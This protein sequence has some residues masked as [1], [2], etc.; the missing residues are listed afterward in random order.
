[1][2]L[3]AAIPTLFLSSLVAVSGQS[4][5]SPAR[6]PALPLAVKSPY[7]STWLAAGSLGGNGG[8]LPGEWPTFWNNIVTGWTGLIRVDNNTY[9]WMGAPLPGVADV[10]LANQ[11]SYTYTSTKSIFSL[12]AGPVTLNVT[13]L[14]PI[15][16]NDI[17]RQ[18]IISSYVDVAVE[19]NDGNSH[20]VQLYTDI[21]AEWVSG[22]RG[23]TVQWNYDTTANG[24][25]YHQVFRQSQLAFTEDAD[26]TEYGN[27]YWA[28][29][30]SDALSYQS[31]ADNDVRGQFQNNGVLTN[32]QDTNFRA[33]NDNYP[34]FGFASALGSVTGSISTLYTIGLY[35]QDAVQFLGQNGVESVPTLWTSYFGSDTD[36][37][38]FFYGDYSTATST[39]NDLDNQ[40]ASDA[41]A[42]GGQDL[43]TI[44]SL[45]VR[46]AFGGTEFGG[47]DDQ[48]LLWM[49]EISSNGNCQTV[50][51][52][53]PLHPIHL[54]FN[55]TYIKYL[56][57]PLFINQ[58]SGNYPNQYSMHDLGAHFPNDTGHTDGQDEFMPVE[59]S[60][61]MLIMT[62]AYAQKTGDNDYLN[63]HYDI[64]KQWTGFL[65]NDSLIPENQVSTDDFA[66]ALAN[67]TNLA[68]KGIIGIAAMAEIANI[69]GNTDDASN[70]RSTAEDYINQWYDLGNA[71][72]AD[73]PHTTLDYGQNDSWN[74]LYNLY[75]DAL[76]GLGL[77]KQEIYT[78]QANWYAT[79]FQEYGVP[80]D[81]RHIYTKGDW[82]M[83]TASVSGSGS[84]N[85]KQMLFQHLAKWIN[86]TPTNQPYGDLY[87][88]DDGGYPFTPPFA[89]RP[90]QGGTF[91]P[92]ILNV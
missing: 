30:S 64:L 62:L 72:G 23:A 91:A 12:D 13:F 90:V 37:L 53:F 55:P 85:T 92:L 71:A 70:F 73:P 35:Q 66:G 84:N 4:T 38:D 65:V 58:E 2:R 88:T 19:S 20:D 34:V 87:N 3:Q 63:Q 40:V 29:Q 24:V 39:S 6:P 69:T 47:T 43:V 60:G 10:Q 78:Q 81:T 21:S 61:N 25:A 18:S 56:L 50:D 17:K 42:V 11:T 46:Q 27:W 26:Q 76:L 80:L 44:T 75:G 16:P 9:T 48:P 86:E 52:I 74:L 7:L 68:L 15:Y 14:S 31:G 67:Q 22:D 41:S 49:K 57:D 32:T 83:F 36:A 1:M 89:A 33:V 51:V 8:Y 59:E 28:T 5:F 79:Q 82:E 54:Y 77:V 45:A